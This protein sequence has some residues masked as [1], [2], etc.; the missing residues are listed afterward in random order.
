V[1][2]AIF[3]FAALVD[4]SRAPL[5]QRAGATVARPNTWSARSTAGL[6][7]GGTWTATPD[8]ANGTVRGTWTLVDAKGLTVARGN[9]SAAKAA[10]GWTGSWRA[11]AAG[12]PGEYS[13]TW[14][15]TVTLKPDGG[16]VELFEQAAQAA[17]SGS[18]R[19][20]GRS[21][22]WSIRA[23]PAAAAARGPMPA[24]LTALMAKAR[25]DGS[26]A[27]WCRAGFRDGQLNAFAL[28]VTA[29]TGGRYVALD[30]DGKASEL[31]KF[32][33]RPDLSCYSRAQAG[34]LNRSLKQSETIHGQITPRFNTT[35]VCAFTEDTTARC[36]Q[37]S[38][39]DSA[40]VEVG[41]WTT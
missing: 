26:A 24:E 30:S 1:L 37:Y 13:G 8:A 2:L 3:L 17:V 11:I 36:W 7:L 19:A 28:A 5:A 40:F 22:S 34:D 33:G 15:T 35:V 23:F 6:T 4:G 14:S 39:T 27:A 20:G 12:R 18:W 31:A 9:W 32:S 41:T 29:G 10:S 38:P 16:F 25:L 21:G